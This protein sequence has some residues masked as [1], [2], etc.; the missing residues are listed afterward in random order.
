[1]K[2]VFTYKCHTRYPELWLFTPVHKWITSSL[3]SL[4]YEP[5]ILPCYPQAEAQ[6]IHHL[7]LVHLAHLTNVVGNMDFYGL[8]WKLESVIGRRQFHVR[9]ANVLRC[10]IIKDLPNIC[11]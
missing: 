6:V 1:M 5:L 9:K 10:K 11:G 3:L 2:V 8:P 7:I 4:S